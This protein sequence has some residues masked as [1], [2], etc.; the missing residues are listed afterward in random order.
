MWMEDMCVISTILALFLRGSCE[1][2]RALAL[3]ESVLAYVSRQSRASEKLNDVLLN[4]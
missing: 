2:D 3:G 4:F 1:L